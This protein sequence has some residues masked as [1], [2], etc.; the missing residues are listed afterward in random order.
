MTNMWAQIKNKPDGPPQSLTTEHYG[1]IRKLFIKRYCQQYGIRTNATTEE[2]RKFQSNH[3]NPR[4][5][6]EIVSTRHGAENRK[7]IIVGIKW[8][9]SAWRAV[10]CSWWSRDHVTWHAGVLTQEDDFRSTSLLPYQLMVQCSEQWTEIDQKLLSWY[11]N[12]NKHRPKGS[13]AHMFW[14]NY[15]AKEYIFLSGAR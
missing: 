5:N 14:N 3:H 9:S 7:S 13:W 8:K 1:K 15:F 6:G 11:W 12:D 2:R 10:Y 4:T